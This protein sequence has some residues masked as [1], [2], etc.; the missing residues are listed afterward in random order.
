MPRNRSVFPPTMKTLAP[1]AL[2]PLALA[3]LALGG[4]ASKEVRFASLALAPSQHIAS[5]YAS[6]VVAAVTLPSYADSQDI[7][8]QKADGS[9]VALGPLWADD[10]SRAMTLQLSRDL[11]AVTGA[12]IAPEPWPFRAEPDA[13]IDVRMDEM[14]ATATGGFRI[15][16]QYFVAPENDGGDRARSFSISVPLSDPGSAAAI[17]A[18]RA[19]AVSRLAEQIVRKGLR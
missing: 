12:K 11:S 14:L 17:A 2:V 15:A 5:H 16:G 18:A 8:E 4:C 13:R 9:I 3:T 10:P 7:Y 19:A 1:L 6:A